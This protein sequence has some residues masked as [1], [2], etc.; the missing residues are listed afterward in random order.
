MRSIPSSLMVPV[1]CSAMTRSPLRVW[2][3]DRASA[4]P[5]FWMVLVSAE[6]PFCATDE[7]RGQPIAVGRKLSGSVNGG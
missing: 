5:L 2:Q 6:Q 7:G 3:S 1:A 4:S